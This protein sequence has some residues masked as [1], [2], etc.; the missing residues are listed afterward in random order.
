[1]PT[2]KQ[3]ELGLNMSRRGTRKQ[4]FLDEMNRAVQWPALVKLIAPHAPSGT[5]GRPPFPI[6]VM[7][8]SP[9]CSSGSA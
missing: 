7:R 5:R 1:M 4:E 8:G 6:E 3:A 2:M 9:S